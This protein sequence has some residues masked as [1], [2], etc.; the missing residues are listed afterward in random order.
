MEQ[1]ND[2]TAMPMRATR[3]GASRKLLTRKAKEAARAL[4]GEPLE[5]SF[6]SASDAPSIP[7]EQ[8]LCASPIALTTAIAELPPETAAWSKED[9]TA[10]QALLIRRKAAGYQRRGRDLSGQVLKPGTIQPNAETI[11]AT[12]VALVAERG[13]VSRSE[14]LGLMA[15]THFPHPKA[16][17]TD[18]G[19]CQGYV[20][21]ALRNGFLAVTNGTEPSP[22]ASEG[23]S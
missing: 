16:Q 2:I 20:A 10:F 13:Q 17:P 15:T 6:P 11:V 12:I 18:N 9:E 14:L 4:T 22:A 21:G 19:W 7:D 5:A 3:S 23:G 8:P 1:A